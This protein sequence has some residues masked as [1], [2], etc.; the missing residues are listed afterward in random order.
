MIRR[1]NLF[2]KD[3]IIIFILNEDLS[4]RYCDIKAILYRE[5]ADLRP[6]ATHSMKQQH[7]TI[8]N[9]TRKSF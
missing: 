6:V 8:F 9:E 3:E 7:R 5:V 4:L 2:E 1:F